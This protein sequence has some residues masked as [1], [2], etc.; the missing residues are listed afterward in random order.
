VAGLFTVAFLFPLY[1]RSRRWRAVQTW[2]RRVVQSA[3]VQVRVNGTVPQRG[4]RVMAVSNHVSWL[5]VQVLH[6]V[7]NVRFVAKSEIRRWPFIGWLS[8]RTGTLFIERG[9]RRLM[10]R[11]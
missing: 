8:A 7:W 11:R 1:D 4:P 9:N 10:R 6:S 5:D 3:G 2:S